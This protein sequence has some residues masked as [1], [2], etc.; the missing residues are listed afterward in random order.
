MSWFVNLPT[1]GKLVLGFGLMIV[2][3]F[4]MM[5]MAY[6]SMTEIQARA[7]NLFDK[8]FARSVGIMTVRNSIN[9]QRAALLGMLVITDPVKLQELQE[10]IRARSEQND[11]I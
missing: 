1:R 10:E 6:F 2:L 8:D 3:L 5:G 7:R 9:R 4:I 11:E